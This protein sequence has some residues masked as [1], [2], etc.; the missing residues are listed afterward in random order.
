MLKCEHCSSQYATQEGLDAHR[1]RKHSSVHSNDPILYLDYIITNLECFTPRQL[2]AEL[3]SLSDV[4]K[5]KT[6]SDSVLIK[7]AMFDA[8]HDICEGRS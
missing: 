5:G 6:Q 4:L 2:Q 8:I 7:A 1:R 3:A